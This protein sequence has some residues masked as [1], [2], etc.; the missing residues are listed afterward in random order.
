MRKINLYNQAINLRQKGLSYNEI[1]KSLPVAQSTLSRWCHDIILT[2]EQKNRLTN[3]QRNTPLISG[4]RTRAIETRKESKVWAQ[5]KIKQLI[6]DKNELLLI[7]GILLYWAEGAKGIQQAIQ[8]TNTDGRII[9]IMMQ[10]FR[11]IMLIPENKFHV[12]VRIGE[13]GNAEEAQEYWHTLTRI[14][15]E[16]FHKPEILRLTEK[17]RSLQKHPHGICRIG[18]YDVVFYTRIIELIEELNKI[19]P[20]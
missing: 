20:L 1:L 7:S 10:F 19:M 14:P 3:K 2:E 9:K 16:N 12:M 11:R 17:S 5:E 4:L 6:A 13:Y 8:F 18:I 15:K